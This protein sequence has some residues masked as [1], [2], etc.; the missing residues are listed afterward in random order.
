MADFQ[1]QELVGLGTRGEENPQK[2]IN[3]VHIRGTSLNLGKVA[4]GLR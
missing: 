2:Q 1:W 3:A 4:R